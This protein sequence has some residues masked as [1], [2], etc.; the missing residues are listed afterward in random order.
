MSS[1]NTTRYSL[2]K[3][4]FTER[5]EETLAAAWTESGNCITI[6][7]ENDSGRE[8]LHR[9]ALALCDEMGWNGNLVGGWTN[10]GIVFVFV[11]V[12]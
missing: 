5:R 8:N 11:D 3:A 7:W 6:P 10:A 9:A 2:C 12:A 4:I 1:V